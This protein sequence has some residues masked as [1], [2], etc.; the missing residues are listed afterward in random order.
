MKSVADPI[1]L[2]DLDNEI[3]LRIDALRSCSA[4]PLMPAKVNAER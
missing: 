4:V 1:V 3:L 2:T